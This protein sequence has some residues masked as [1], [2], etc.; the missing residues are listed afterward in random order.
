MLL[1]KLQAM[2]SAAM[3]WEPVHDQGKVLVRESS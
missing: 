1:E 2:D 3:N